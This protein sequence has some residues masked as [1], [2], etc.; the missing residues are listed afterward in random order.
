MTDEDR[1][2]QKFALEFERIQPIGSGPG[3]SLGFWSGRGDWASY[4]AD[5]REAAGHR[6]VGELDELIEKLTDFR[7]RLAEKVNQT[8]AH[9]AGGQ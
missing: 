7:A 9:Q 5:A 1:E 4:R 3:F 6:A 8:P 2:R